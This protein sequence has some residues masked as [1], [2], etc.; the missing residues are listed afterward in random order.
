MKKILLFLLIF[1]LCLVGCQP[2]EPVEGNENSNNNQ[3]NESAENVEG[4]ENSDNNQNNETTEKTP[5]TQITNE[6]QPQDENDDF[7][8]VFKGKSGYFARG[9]MME[10]EIEIIN[11]TGEPHGYIGAGEFTAHPRLHCIYNG[12]EY[13]LSKEPGNSM[14]DESYR[15]V[16]PGGSEKDTFYYN[17]PA[18][19]PLGEYTLTCFYNGFRKDFV[20]YFTLK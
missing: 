5:A 10:L 11:N 17:I 14:P 3:N 13:V 16:E 9:E 8:F 18:D 12:E 6:G 15:E 20:G 2:V 19:A 1:T 7:L 4:N